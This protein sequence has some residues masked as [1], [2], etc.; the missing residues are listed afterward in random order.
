M[1]FCF[2]IKKQHIE[3]NLPR[4]I[5][6]MFM[7]Q[8]SVRLGLRIVT[9]EFPLA[10]SRARVSQHLSTAVL[11]NM[12][13]NT[14]IR[15]MGVFAIAAL[16]S[17]AGCNSD[18]EPTTPAEKWDYPAMAV[19]NSGITFVPLPPTDQVRLVGAN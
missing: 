1:L 16:I 8:F 5:A 15:C 13:C 2:H 19:S 12:I 11:M 10:R 4:S 17:F 3:L 14:N 7:S 9:R 18:T 6:R